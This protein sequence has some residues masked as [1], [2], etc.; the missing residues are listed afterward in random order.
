[1]RLPSLRL[2]LGLAILGSAL[3]SAADGPTLKTS[4]TWKPTS[5]VLTS[6][7]PVNL[8]PFAKQKIVVMP[9]V[10]KRAEKNL[11]GENTEKGYS[12]YVATDDNIA[13]FVTKRLAALLAQ[14]GLP[15]SA[16]AEGATVVVSG[17]L[18]RYYVTETSTYKGEFRALLQVESRGK[19]LWKG[20]A[21]GENTRFGRSYKLENY[22]ETLSDILIDAIGRL[23]SDRDFMAALAA[24]PAPAPV[25]APAK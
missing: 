1:M 14:P 2:L 9:L 24:T 17:E 6:S 12:R 21:A 11:V 16:Q 25:P 7:T 3:L 22:H 5:A 18:Q 20:L 19:I 15:V 13:D 10:D 23:L 8:M 4:L